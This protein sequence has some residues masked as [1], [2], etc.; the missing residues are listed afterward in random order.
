MK[1]IHCGKVLP[2]NAIKCYSCGQSTGRN[3]KTQQQTP[4]SNSRQSSTQYGKVIK[5]PICGTDF[6]AFETKCTYCGY[7]LRGVQ[8]S[9]AIVD[10]VEKL[11]NA[12]TEQ[13]K[14][15]LIKTF[16][17][18]NTKEDI[19][20]FMILASSNFDATYYANH[21]QQEDISD[22]WL[23]KI[24]QAYLKAKLIFGNDID[25]QT[26][27]NL[28]LEVKNKCGEEELKI[29]KK[30]ERVK[31]KKSKM[32]KVIIVFII[33]SAVFCFGAFSETKIEA[34]M[35]AMAQII[36]FTISY[37]MGCGVLKEPIKNLRLIPAILSFLI[38]IPYF[39]FYA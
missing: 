28:Y 12:T 13:Q 22:A 14:I 1:C 23:I 8:G 29:S 15:M 30:Q 6:R 32:K 17:I 5:C 4:P 20:E 2:D 3:S 10:L 31:F 21:L 16:P 37:L 35:C 33:I 19:F 11:E 7:E 38:F 26:V 34:G 25:F 24:E 18:P 39:L 9:Q 27:K 36:L